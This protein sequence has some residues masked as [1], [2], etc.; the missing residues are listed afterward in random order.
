MSVVE[1]EEGFRLEM[2]EYIR[3][4]NELKAKLGVIVEQ[5][6]GPE[7][8]LAKAR[9]ILLKAK[10]AYEQILEEVTPLRSDK[11]LLEGELTLVE[12]KKSKL[13]QEALFQR[14]GGGVRPGTGALVEQMNQLGG[15]PEE[16]RMRKEVAAAN[17]A[18]ALA[19]LKAKMGG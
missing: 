10:A 12:E 1:M 9:A 8:K 14:G 16:A 7:E 18:E 2:A 19:A 4:E 11:T 5:L 6:K 17:A 13:R 15:D 3:Q